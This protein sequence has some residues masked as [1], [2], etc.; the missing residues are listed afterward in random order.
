LAVNN[1]HSSDL[2][3]SQSYFLLS[4]A[5]IVFNGVSLCKKNLTKLLIRNWCI[6]VVGTC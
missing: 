6:I 1:F 4:E 5:S 3:V 2:F